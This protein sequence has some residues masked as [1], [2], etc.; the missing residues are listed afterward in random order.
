MGI[1]DKKQMTE[2]DIK[3]NFITPAILSKGWQDKITM[4]TQ[5]RFTDGKVNL[6]GNIVNREAPKKA[7][8]VLYFAKNN[9]LAVVEAKDNNHNVSF[10]MQQAKLYA[11]MLD[12]KFAYSSNGD[13]FQEF[14]FITG[15]ERN[16]VGRISVSRRIVCSLSER[17]KRRT[18]V[19]GERTCSHQSAILYKPKYLSSEILSAGCRQPHN[20][21]HRKGA[22][23][24]FACHGDGNRENLYR[25]S[26]RVSLAAERRK[27]KDTLPCRP[28]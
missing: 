23:P 6:R 19:I 28:Q 15:V 14:D 1:I 3:L 9:P 4:E 24:H 13:A 5:L 22:K 20:R 2:E 7:D 25:L 27:A 18:R 10:G 12:V 17:N 16:C 21:R 26:N 11:Q 8:Y